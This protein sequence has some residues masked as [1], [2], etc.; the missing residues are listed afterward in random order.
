M[1]NVKY[2]CLLTGGL[3]VVSLTFARSVDVFIK[4]KPIPGVRF[5][6]ALV[7][8]QVGGV[9]P[10]FKSGLLIPGEATRIF[11]EVPDLEK[12]K[13]YGCTAEGIYKGYPERAYIFVSDVK[14]N[15]E[16]ISAGRQPFYFE[17]MPDAMD[18]RVF[19]DDAASTEPKVITL[20]GKGFGNAAWDAEWD[21]ALAKVQEIISG[22]SELAP[23]GVSGLPLHLG[24]IGLEDFQYKYLPKIDPYS[25]PAVKA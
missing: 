6:Y 25:G 20:Y 24:P 21:A 8:G 10:V 16:L 14:R 9:F 5:S 13:G 22:P 12:M 1:V 19:Y 3:A 23:A 7:C 4:G 15:A 2:G 17:M 11:D 18:G